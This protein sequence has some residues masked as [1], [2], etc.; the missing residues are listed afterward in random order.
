[1]E[2]NSERSVDA[3]ETP[4]S[5][6][7]ELRAA[8]AIHDAAAAVRA[9]DRLRARIEADRRRATPRGRRR[10]VYG[11][12]LASAVAAVA[13]ALVLLL[14]AGTPGAPSVSEA[15][16]LA[17]RGSAAAAPSSD[18]QAPD[19]RLDQRVGVLYFPNWSWRFGWTA[20]GQR[21]DVLSGRK[22]LTVF[23][24]GHQSTIAYTI[25]SGSVLARPD[26]SVRHLGR[27]EL[28]LLSVDGRLLVSWRRDGH[29]CLLSGM[30]VTATQLER[31]AAWDDAGSPR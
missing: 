31:L 12:G 4:D 25:V 17:V 11:I 29:T 15:A 23:Y 7:R 19:A 1:M 3:H 21:S 18:P 13:L 22:M 5:E 20:V 10:T 2:D 6:P 28:R 24:Q 26:G 8:A 30:G 27:L 16:A 9:P 14:P